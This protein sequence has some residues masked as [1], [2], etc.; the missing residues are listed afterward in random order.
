MP[1]RRGTYSSVD[2]LEAAIYGYLT[3]HNVKPK[4][5][6]WIK[7]EGSILT[8][9]LDK[10]DETR[11]NRQEVSGSEHQLVSTGRCPASQQLPR[12][13]VRDQMAAGRFQ[14]VPKAACKAAHA[15]HGQ[16]VFGAT[17]HEY[18]HV[19]H[20][21]AGGA[22]GFEYRGVQ[23]DELFHDRADRTRTVIRR[24]VET[25]PGIGLFGDRATSGLYGQRGGEI[26]GRAA[27]ASII[28]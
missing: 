28:H 22:A 21:G 3:R 24:D 19:V 18:A 11:G 27:A 13:G 15:D 4:P 2:D 9:A 20:N 17:D 7:T 8:R 1:V 14:R 10:L 26:L 5:F 12:L 16:P 25:D 6:K 23:I